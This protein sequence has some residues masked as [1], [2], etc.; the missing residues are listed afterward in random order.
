MKI[1]LRILL[2]IPSASVERNPSKLRIIKSYLGNT[3]Y[4]NKYGEPSTIVAE[5]SDSMDLN[6]LIESFISGKIKKNILLI[7]N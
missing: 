4:R 3:V 7:C 5:I 6:N 1:C 2:T